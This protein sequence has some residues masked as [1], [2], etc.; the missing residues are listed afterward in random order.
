MSDSLSA[1]F[2]S[3]PDLDEI[4]ERFTAAF[5]QGRFFPEGHECS[6]YVRLANDVQPLLREI[7]RLRA[8]EWSLLAE[9]WAIADLRTA[10]LVRGSDLALR[11]LERYNRATGGEVWRRFAPLEEHKAS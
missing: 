2:P 5:V 11:A 10:D 7:E 3:S 9:L 1:E 4:R 8:S 6:P